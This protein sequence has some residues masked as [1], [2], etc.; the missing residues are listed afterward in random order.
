[1]RQGTG[2]RIPYL[3]KFV[4]DQVGYVVGYTELDGKVVVK[5]IDGGATWAEVYVHA[6]AF[7]RIGSDL[8][9]VDANTVWLGGYTSPYDDSGEVKLVT[10]DGGVTWNEAPRTSN[11]VGIDAIDF[12]DA[13]HG[14]AVGAGGSIIATEDG[15]YTWQ[16]QQVPRLAD[17]DRVTGEA[18]YWAA[19]QFVDA[20]HGWIVGSSFPDTGQG[21]IL[22]TDTGGW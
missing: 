20:Q 18:L 22:A 14:W 5:T 2:A 13:L 4:D 8:E 17:I 11:R 9:V 21:A 1:M 3:A 7:N 16:V 15:G 10:R 12:I 19:I 6:D